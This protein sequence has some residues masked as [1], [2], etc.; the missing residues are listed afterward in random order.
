MEIAWR[1]GYIDA[2]QVGQLA[3]PYLQNEYGQYLMDIINEKD[4]PSLSY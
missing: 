3:Q 4:M 1:M 2:H